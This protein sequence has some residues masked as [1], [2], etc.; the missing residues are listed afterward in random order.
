MVG[1]DQV[2]GLEVVGVISDLVGSGLRPGGDLRPGW[3]GLRPVGGGLRPGG[4][5]RPVGD[6]MRPGVGGL[7]PPR[8]ASHGRKPSIPPPSPSSRSA[9][10]T[11]HLQGH[12]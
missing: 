5:Q 10:Q 3:G 2:E 8:S 4:G 7:R 1:S 6:G 11:L 12:S 9:R